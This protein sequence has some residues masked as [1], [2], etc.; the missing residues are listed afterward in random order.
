M[1]VLRDGKRKTLKAK[2]EE[3]KDQDGRAVPARSSQDESMTGLGV[4]V[5]DL[6]DDERETLG[7]ERGGVVIVGMERDGPAARAGIRKG[8]VIRRVGRSSIDSAR[9]LRKLVDDLPKGKPVSVLVQRG[10]N[11]LFVAITID[12]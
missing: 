10:D 1:L 12:D 3:L 5:R 8:D 6:T 2:I 7:I 11:P 9:Q 4:Q